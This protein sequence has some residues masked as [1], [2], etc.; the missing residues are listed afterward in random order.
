MRCGVRSG[1]RIVR[2]GMLNSHRNDRIH[3]GRRQQ[4]ACVRLGWKVE[5]E[6]SMRAASRLGMSET[7]S[8]ALQVGPAETL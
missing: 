1:R 7:D 5:P 4:G 6:R 3:P 8:S 2:L